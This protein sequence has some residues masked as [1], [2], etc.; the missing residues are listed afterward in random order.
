MKIKKAAWKFP[1]N[2]T[3]T[4]KYKINKTDENYVTVHN[5]DLT[6][7]TKFLGK[8]L[9]CHKGKAVGKLRINK[10]HLGYKLGEFFITKILGERIS[11]RKKQKLL[12]KKTKSKQKLL[13]K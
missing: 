7:T 11:Y 6:L 13:K 3:R 5:R 2:L 4:Y 9:R 12:A 1:F 8:Q 10:Q